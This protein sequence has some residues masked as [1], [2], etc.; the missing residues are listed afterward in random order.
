M[1]SQGPNI[2]FAMDAEA[3][4]ALAWLGLHPNLGSNEQNRDWG[5]LHRGQS[6]RRSRR[7]CCIV[8]AAEWRPV[9]GKRFG[10]PS[11]ASSH[12]ELLIMLLTE[13]IVS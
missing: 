12:S 6:S 9:R 8:D 5:S 13:Y 7:C 10:P 2:T 4:S 1:C 11:G 3:F